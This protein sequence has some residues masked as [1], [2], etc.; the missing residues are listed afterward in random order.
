MKIFLY[1]I[2]AV[3]LAARGVLFFLQ[4]KLHKHRRNDDRYMAVSFIFLAFSF[5]LYAFEGNWP[6]SGTSQIVIDSILAVFIVYT[7]VRSL[8]SEVRLRRKEG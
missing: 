2:I 1:L 3:A 5:G 4:W 8:I 6:P 7:V